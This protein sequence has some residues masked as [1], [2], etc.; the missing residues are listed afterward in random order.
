[1]HRKVKGESAV[2][3]ERR[4]HGDVNVAVNRNLALLRGKSSTRAREEPGVSPATSPL[5][6]PQP[7]L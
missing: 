2:G 5:D 6:T 3:E 4:R 7:A 1:M